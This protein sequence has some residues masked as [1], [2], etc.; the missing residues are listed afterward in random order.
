MKAKI[1]TT[2]KAFELNRVTDYGFFQDSDDLFYIKYISSESNS[3]TFVFP[4]K[5]LIYMCFE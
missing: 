5:E 4:I 1:I 3:V 2:F